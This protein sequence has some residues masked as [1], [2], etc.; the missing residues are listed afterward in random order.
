MGCG[1]KKNKKEK[2]EQSKNMNS[3]ALRTLIRQKIIEQV[4]KG[5]PNPKPS[6]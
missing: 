4:Q 1:C 5:N 2:K 3:P 6:Q